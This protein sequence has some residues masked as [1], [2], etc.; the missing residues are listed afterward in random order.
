MDALR[1]LF[2]GGGR[3]DDAARR[4]PDAGEARRPATDEEIE[5]DERTH[6]LELL[7]AEQGRLS[8]LVVRQQRYADRS[9]T[10]QAQGGP[11]RAEDGDADP[12]RETDGA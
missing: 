7:R 3:D 10:P 11:R 12:G 2:G 4:D 6:E 9:W 5:A 8:D 1:R